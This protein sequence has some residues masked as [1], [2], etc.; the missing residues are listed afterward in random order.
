MYLRTFL[1]SLS[2]PSSPALFRPVM[3]LHTML[4]HR[5]G[6]WNN[7]LQY[8]LNCFPTIISVIFLPIDQFIWN[9]MS[10]CFRK[11]IDD[12]EHRISATGAQI[13]RDKSVWCTTQAADGINMTF[14]QI[15]NVNVITD[16]SAIVRIII[17]AENTDQ[18]TSSYS[19]LR[20]VWHQV[21]W[22]AIWIFANEAR[23]MSGHW[24]EISQ[25]NDLPTLVIMEITEIFRIEPLIRIINSMFANRLHLHCPMNRDLSI[26]PRWSIYFYR[27]D[28][29]NCQ[30]DA[31]LVLAEFSVHH[32]PLHWSCRP[33]WRRQMRPSPPTEC[34]FQ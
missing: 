32:T 12:I 22:F 13:V 19:R 7:Q 14:G 17:A 29:Y 28:W 23:W 16:A 26:S 18:R 21:V 9:I 11:W 10:R 27:M 25:W 31:F 6:A 8:I 34:S 15:N 1:S 30:L 4:P 3:R 5:Q 24:I 33:I 2:W 20:Y